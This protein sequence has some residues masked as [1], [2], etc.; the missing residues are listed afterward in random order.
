[1]FHSH[2]SDKTSQVSLFDL[3]P[4]G[5]NFACVCLSICLSDI[6]LAFP[7]ERLS[8]LSIIRVIDA[9]WIQEFLKDSAPTVLGLGYTNTTH[10]MGIYIL[11]F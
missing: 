3:L 11:F 2:L 5:Y 1:M 7:G 6:F 4:R 8:R 9:I 10:H